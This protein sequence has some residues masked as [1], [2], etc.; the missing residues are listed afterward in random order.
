MNM[1]SRNRKIVVIL[2]VET[3]GLYGYRYMLAILSIEWEISYVHLL[4]CYSPQR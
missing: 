4:Y 1:S 2:E 3:H